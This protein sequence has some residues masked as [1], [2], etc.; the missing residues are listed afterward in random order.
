MLSFVPL[1]WHISGN[2]SSLFQAH[3]L[4]ANFDD[5]SSG[6]EDTA[7]Y[8]S[9]EAE[10]AEKEGYDQGKPGSFLNKLIQHGNKKTEDQIARESAVASA[11]Q[12]GGT[13]ELVTGRGKEE[14]GV[15]R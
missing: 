12:T 2:T 9:K 13:Q 10:S 7:N 8:V 14:E 6:D 4:P 5:Y 3:N 15:V 1:P 11:G